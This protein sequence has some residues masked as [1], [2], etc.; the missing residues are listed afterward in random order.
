VA[1]LLAV[2]GNSSEFVALLAI[3]GGQPTV[4]FRVGSWRHA[5]YAA[6]GVSNADLTVTAVQPHECI[7][8]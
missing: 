2:H 3:D 8:G 4:I 1:R 6:D 5:V 7:T